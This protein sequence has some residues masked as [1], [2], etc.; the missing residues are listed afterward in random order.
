M[1]TADTH[2]SALL[3]GQHRLALRA[4]LGLQRAAGEDRWLRVPQIAARLGAGQVEAQELLTD[5]SVRGLLQREMGR[6]EDM[7]RLTRQGRDLAVTVTP[8]GVIDGSRA[9]PDLPRFGADEND[10]DE[11][12]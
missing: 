12:G 4:V 1:S 5:L 9:Y 8:S 3:G 11:V 2:V 10:L 7:F 6:H